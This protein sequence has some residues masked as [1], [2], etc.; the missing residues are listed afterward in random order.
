VSNNEGNLRMLESGRWAV[1]VR[2][3]IPRSHLAMFSASNSNCELKT[4]ATL[5]A[6]N[7]GIE[8]HFTAA[9]LS[10]D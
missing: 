7:G 10:S 1:S 4:N 9:L 3:A 5:L 6:C 8:A 2:G